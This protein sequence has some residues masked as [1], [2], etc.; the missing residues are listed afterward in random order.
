MTCCPRLRRSC[1]VRSVA[2]APAVRAMAP[3]TPAAAAATR[4]ERLNRRG[5]E[6]SSAITAQNVFVSPSKCF[7]F[8]QQAI[9]VEGEPA[10]WL[11]KRSLLL[12][13]RCGYKHFRGLPRARAKQHC[14][15]A[16]A[17]EDRAEANRA[18]EARA[19]WTPVRAN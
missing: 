5:A 12:Y 10:N 19:A 6:S 7:R 2:A 16:R 11:P 15:C 9:M 3:P 1:S 14:C 13:S 4:S 8:A 17:A 18:A